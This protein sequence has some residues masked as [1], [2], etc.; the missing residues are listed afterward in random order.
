MLY[1][2]ILGLEFQIDEKREK[3]QLFRYCS[4]ESGFSMRASYS[5]VGGGVGQF[6][7]TRWELVMVSAAGPSQYVSLR[8]YDALVAAGGGLRE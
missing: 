4:A 6:Y 5:S 7:I 8:L 3:F 1:K 2:R